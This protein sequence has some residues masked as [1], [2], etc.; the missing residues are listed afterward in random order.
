M[1]AQPVSQPNRRPISSRDHAYTLP[2][3]G[4]RDARLP[5][6]PQTNSWPTRTSGNAHRKAGPAATMPMAN[7]V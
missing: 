5:K 7:T 3:S 2:C 1:Y 4:H 6:T